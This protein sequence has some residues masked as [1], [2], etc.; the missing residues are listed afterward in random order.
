MWATLSSFAFVAAVSAPTAAHANVPPNVD[1]DDIDHWEQAAEEILDLPR[2]C[3]EWVGQA[4]WDW[5]T[6]PFTSRGDAVFAGKTDNGIWGEV[7]LQPLGELLQDRR[8]TTTRVFEHEDARFAP[9]VGRLRGGRVVVSGDEDGAA[10]VEGA[11]AINVLRSALHRI[12]GD[13]FTSWA[14]WDGARGGVVLHRSIPLAKGRAEEIDVSIFFPSGGDVPSLLDVNFPVKFRTGKWP[15]SR[16]VRDAEV[17]VRGL[18]RGNVVYP[19]SE[20]FRFEYRVLGFRYHG[21]QTVVY[22]RISRCEIDS[23]GRPVATPAP[24]V[25]PVPKPEQDDSVTA[26]AETVEETDGEEAAPQEDPEGPAEGGAGGGEAPTPPEDEGST[27]A[28]TAPDDREGDAEQRG[29]Q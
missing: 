6:G 9:L 27:S 7:H 22:K 21:A 24:L 23:Q 11:E 2:G 29:S 16:T 12:G 15:R 17:H 25:A 19:S 1:L 5:R 20:A 28:S 10:M 13:A 3:W 8:G 26:D 18:V 14:E 4:S